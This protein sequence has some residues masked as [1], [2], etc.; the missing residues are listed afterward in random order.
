MAVGE[1]A[2][3]AIILKLRD[4]ISYRDVNYSELRN[5]LRENG[6]EVDV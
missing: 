3:T 2:G 1:A 5:V 6:A 4:N